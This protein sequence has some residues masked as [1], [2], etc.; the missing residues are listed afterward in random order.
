[1]RD[2]R[3]LP[4][5]LLALL[6]PTAVEQ[7]A[8]GPGADLPFRFNPVLDGKPAYA[9]D[10]TTG[11]VWAAWAYKSRG[12]FDIAFSVRE[13][14]GTWSEPAFI[15]RLDG[16]DQLAP[17]LVSDPSGNI[18]LAFAV[19]QTSQIFLAVLP[20]GESSWSAPVLATSPGERG[21]SPTVAV[22]ADYLVLGYRGADGKVT[23][24]GAPLVGAPA[25]SNGMLS[26]KI[27]LQGVLP[28]DKPLVPNGIYD[29]PDGV[30]PL[31]VGGTGTGT[32]TGASTGSAPID[33]GTVPGSGT[34]K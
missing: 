32:G 16:L 23:L 11:A 8:A 19:R 22:L 21:F 20:R 13:L 10:A 34:A 3:V 17:A 18:Y 27:A 33:A 24:R 1:M 15:G 28:I 14:A 26:G 12:E 4:I 29:N 25:V 7:A 6:V 2:R 5:L 30:D 31:G 9:T